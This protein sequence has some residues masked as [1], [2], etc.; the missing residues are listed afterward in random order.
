MDAPSLTPALNP[1]L[2]AALMPLDF[3]GI[4]KGTTGL[5]EL[6]SICIDPLCNDSVAL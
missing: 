1:A 2:R 4:G 5:E 6:E 3:V